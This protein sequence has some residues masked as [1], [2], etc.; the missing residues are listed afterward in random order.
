MT[1]NNILELRRAW[2]VFE[3]DSDTKHADNALQTAL[4]MHRYIED[5]ENESSDTKSLARTIISTHFKLITNKLSEFK[6]DNGTHEIDVYLQWGL[7]A[8]EFK[9]VVG[10]QSRD[11][12]FEF[13]KLAALTLSNNGREN[14]LQR[15]N[16]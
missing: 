2:A 8:S 14:L 3:R 10:V 4:G 16:N 13:F 7:I 6:N 15:L 11:A 9:G 5:D 1:E 12:A